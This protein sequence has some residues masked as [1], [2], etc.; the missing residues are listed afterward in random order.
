LRIIIIL[1]TVKTNK[2]CRKESHPH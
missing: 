1:E 2:Y